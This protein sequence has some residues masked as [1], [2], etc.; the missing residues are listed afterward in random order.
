MANRR[1]VFNV[2]PGVVVV[3]TMTIALALVLIVDK[4]TLAQISQAKLKY[5]CTQVQSAEQVRKV[6]EQ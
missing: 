1:V 3:C 5:N 6:D 2:N 4:I